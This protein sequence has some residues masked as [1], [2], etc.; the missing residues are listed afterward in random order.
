[1][2]TLKIQAFY[3]SMS[4]RIGSKKPTRQQAFVLV[5]VLVSM[6]ILAI[7]GTVLMRSLMNS[8]EI[9]RIVRDTTKAVFLTQVKLHE[10]ELAYSKKAGMDL[11]EFEGRY[12]Q[13]GASKFRWHARVET[14]HEHDAYVI[15][16]WTSWGE[17]D[18]SRRR[19]S[20]WSRRSTE[21]FMLKTMVPTARYNEDLIF[22]NTPQT[23]E[24]GSSRNRSRGRSRG[25]RR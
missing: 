9:S 24:R 8:M 16:I 18:R 11:G 15:Q 2:V 7:A 5:E 6:T 23:R 17:D 12:T 1:M 25:G 19:R 10:F 20:R 22:G 3:K 4:C 21:G 13:P 14:D